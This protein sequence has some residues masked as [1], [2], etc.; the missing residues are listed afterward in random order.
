MT[1]IHVKVFRLHHRQ[2]IDLK[3]SK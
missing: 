3:R 1:D 2:P